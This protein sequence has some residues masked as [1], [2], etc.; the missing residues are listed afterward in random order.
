MRFVGVVVVVVVVAAASLLLFA[1][2]AV[3]KPGHGPDAG[4]LESASI[5]GPGIDGRARLD[6]DGRAATALFRHSGMQWSVLNGGTQL[7]VVAPPS[8]AERGPRYRVTYR[9]TPELAD[10]LG[11]P[12]L[13][14]FFYPYAEGRPWVYTLDRPGLAAASWWPVSLQLIPDYDLLGLPRAGEVNVEAPPHLE[15]TPSAPPEASVWWVI[16]LAVV[17]A[18][19]AAALGA[20]LRSGVAKP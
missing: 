20:R 4:E 15:Q 2:Y 11:T 13:H 8:A 18:G 10:R 19:G 16:A 3:A 6:G 5:A 1:P 12:A 7:S 17:A 9:L 14:Q